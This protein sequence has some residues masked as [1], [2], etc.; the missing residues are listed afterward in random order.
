MISFKD[1]ICCPTRWYCKA[2]LTKVRLVSESSKAKRFKLPTMF[3]KSL[4]FLESDCFIFLAIF[5]KSV[6]AFTCA[7]F[8]MNLSGFSLILANS[9][10]T[11]WFS[12]QSGP[13]I[14]INPSWLTN[15]KSNKTVII[16]A[17][18]VR[19]HRIFKR[20]I[21]WKDPQ[22]Q[23]SS[24]STHALRKGNIQLLVSVILIICRDIKKNSA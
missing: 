23:R 1:S 5:V 7:M 24:S 19:T 10:K 17:T 3:C 13:R 9:L 12:T 11:F 2:D 22:L 6:L 4:A 20:L 18:R 15:W 14:F 8:S 16:R 21:L